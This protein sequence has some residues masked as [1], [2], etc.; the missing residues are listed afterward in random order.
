MT[1]PCW[2]RRFYFLSG[3][4]LLVIG[5]FWF[6]SRQVR[7]KDQPIAYWFEGLPR[8][9]VYPGTADSL[10]FRNQ[11]HWRPSTNYFDSPAESLRA[12]QA[13]GM[14][15]FPFLIRKLKGE[16]PWFQKWI[17]KFFV[18]IKRKIPAKDIAA[19]RDR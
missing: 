10:N 13:I 8:S 7:Y 15:E 12:I 19:D 5:I 17:E 4:L 2:N 11:V 3:I 14:Q 9:S 18:M 16:Q 6:N 1:P